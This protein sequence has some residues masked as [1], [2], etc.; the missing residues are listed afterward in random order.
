M[1][2]PLVPDRPLA[3]VTGATGFLGRYVVAALAEAGWRTRLLVRQDPVHELWRGVEPEIVPGD[4]SDEGALER[5]VAGADA[6][7]HLAGLIKAVDRAGFFRV[8]E[9]G[10]AA[11]ARAT[12]TAAPGARMVIVSSLAAREPQ[13][14]DYAASKRAGEAAAIRELGD[15]PWVVVRPAGVYGPGDR[16]SLALFKA[17]A[18]KLAPVL[19]GREARLGWIHAEDAARAIAA[20]AARGAPCGEIY[21]L[22][23]ARTDGYS[24]DEM[25]D[26]AAAAVGNRPVRLRPPAA[27][28]RVIGAASGWIARA[29]RR[30]AMLT[31]G[32]VREALHPDWS[33]A[34]ARQPP[35]EFWKPRISLAEG[36]AAT[37]LW[38]RER[39]WLP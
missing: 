39:G 33:C 10:S 27:L 12:V 17:A 8:N 16:E 6:I 2:A 4:L 21:E 34:A 5:L 7:I 15:R 36:F 30:P 1:T 35:P 11:L 20:L 3:A 25:L 18:G 13:L 28:L 23:D 32:K 29:R 22:S 26:A 24:W 14:S 38:Y 9:G 37:A 31:A 19:G